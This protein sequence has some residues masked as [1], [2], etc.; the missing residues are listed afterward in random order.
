MKKYKYII[1]FEAETDGAAAIEISLSL[2]L[3]MK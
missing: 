1:Y 2:T 3:A